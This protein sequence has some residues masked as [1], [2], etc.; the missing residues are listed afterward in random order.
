MV[1]NAIWWFGD[2]SVS[3]FKFLNEGNVMQ[4]ILDFLRR[5]VSGA[6]HLPAHNTSLSAREC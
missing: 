6:R 4:K 5:E 1:A 2:E 3:F